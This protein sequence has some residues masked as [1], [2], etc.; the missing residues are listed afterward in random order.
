[1]IDTNHY[2]LSIAADDA[3]RASALYLESVWNGAPLSARALPAI[4]PPTIKV[5]LLAGLG[6]LLEPAVQ[7]QFYSLLR[8]TPMRFLHTDLGWTG[9]GAFVGLAMTLNAFVD[10]GIGHRLTGR[11][12]KPYLSLHIVF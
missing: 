5:G 2:A 11:D 1:W 9:R 8:R 12:W 6:T 3:M 4:H 10:L 7:W